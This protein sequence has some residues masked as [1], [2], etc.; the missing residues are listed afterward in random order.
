MD[1]KVRDKTVKFLKKKK[2]VH[3]HDLGLG[4]GILDTTSNTKAQEKNIKLDFSTKVFV[5]PTL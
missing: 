5:L 2:S 3:L 1:P 4:N